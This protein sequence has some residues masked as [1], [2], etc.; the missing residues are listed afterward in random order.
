MKRLL[1]LLL[2]SFL[3]LAAFADA[4][5]PIVFQRDQWDNSTR[6]YSVAQP[7]SNASGLFIYD[8][9]NK[10]VIVAP[11]SMSTGFTITGGLLYATPPFSSITSL[12]TTLAGYGITDAV[13]SSA[14]TTAL[15]AKFNTPTG[16][17]S[18]Y[19]RG[20]GTLATL[21]TAA[22]PT[23]SSATRT[24]NS[25]FQISTSHVSLVSYSVQIT[26]TASITGGQQGDIVLEIASDSG[27]TTNV[28]TIAISGA[29]QSYSLAVALQGVQP[30]TSVISGMVP[31]GYYTRLRTVNTTGT[32]TFAYRAGQEV[33]L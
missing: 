12:P 31:L 30:Q 24:L 17:T 19:V 1:S 21:P 14:L 5:D 25:A 15:A 32:P 8:G 23:Q 16:T 4:N 20:D 3:S 7:A 9:V 2:L 26:V 10:T 22:T 6:N 11:Y 29:G 27:F 28:Q 33:L 13:T 18:Q